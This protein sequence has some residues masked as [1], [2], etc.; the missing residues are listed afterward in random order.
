[1]AETTTVQ[2]MLAAG[3]AISGG[4]RYR[5]AAPPGVR[6]TVGGL[7]PELIEPFVADFAASQRGGRATRAY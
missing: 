6:V 7:E 1:M 5:F 2:A 3:W 4:E